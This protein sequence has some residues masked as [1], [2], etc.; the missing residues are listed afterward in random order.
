MKNTGFELQQKEMWPKHFFHFKYNNAT[1]RAKIMARRK[2]NSTLVCLPIL[3][4]LVGQATTIGQQPESILHWKNG[5]RLPGQV[6]SGNGSQTNWKSL[7]FDAPLEISNAA[8]TAIE[9]PVSDEAEK[10]DIK[11]HA[12]RLSNGDQING[13]ITSVDEKSVAIST[14]HYG[15]L[16]LDKDSVDSIS[17]LTSARR[18]RIN[19]EDLSNWKSSSGMLKRW[20]LN[21]TRRLTTSTTNATI[22]NE[23][24]L[25]D[26]V[27][28][29][30]LLTSKSQLNFVLAF[31]AT[32]NANL[33]EGLPRIESWDGTIVF[34][35]GAGNL[36]SFFESADGPLKRLRLSFVWDQKKRRIR[37]M[38]EFGRQLCDSECEPGPRDISSGVLI[39]NRST[40]L[41]VETLNVGEATIANK[42]LQTGI[43]R[44]NGEITQGKLKSFDGKQWI[45]EHDQDSVSIPA[46]DFLAACL[47]ILGKDEPT[48]NVH[49]SASNLT[50]VFYRDGSFIKGEIVGLSNDF[51]ELKTVHAD[52]PIRCLFAGLSTLQFPK[53]AFKEVI[54]SHRLKLTNTSLRGKL[55]SGTNDN[56]DVIRW[57][58]VGGSKPVPIKAADALVTL[59]KHT[60]NDQVAARK[61]VD[62]LWSDKIYFRDK[63][64]IVCDIQSIDDKGINFTSFSEKSFVAHSDV[65]AVEL[66]APVSETDVSTLDKDWYFSDKNEIVAEQTAEHFKINGNGQFDFGHPRLG[67]GKEIQFDIS[68]SDESSLEI[69]LFPFVENTKELTNEAGF[70]L[71]VVKNMI[72]L[73]KGVPSNFE[74]R[75]A[76]VKVR[77]I[78]GRIEL[79]LN[80]RKIQTLPRQASGQG[81]GIRLRSL[82]KKSAI[83][84][85]G[86]STSHTVSP[87]AS[88]NKEK[89]RQALT[90]PR[91]QKQNP[92]KQILCARNGDLLR[93]HLQSL[94]NNGIRFQSNLDDFKFTREL[95]GSIVW[96]HREEDPLAETDDSVEQVSTVENPEASAERIRPQK[97]KH[98]QFVLIDGP[99]VTM[100]L[101]SWRDG[102][103]VG[104]SEKLGLCK[105]P[106][107][108][109]IEMR[110]GRF[111]TEAQDGPYSDWVAVPAM[112]VQLEG[113][114]GA[115]SHC[116]GSALSGLVGETPKDLEL[117]MVDGSLVNLSELRGKV[118][119]LDFWATWCGPCI[120]ALPEVSRT[121]DSFDP[122]DVVLIAVNQGE[123]VEHI[124]SFQKRRKWKIQIATD[125]DSAIGKTF[126]ASSLPTT[127]V[128]DPTGKIAA[129]HVGASKNLAGQLKEEIQGLIRAKQN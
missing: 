126:E 82:S 121:V 11:G 83:T 113:G 85:S 107:T 68:W 19:F 70:G 41:T 35:D 58:P 5:D 31:G 7:F 96:L 29:D 52:V 117:K 91:L 44:F 49:K 69:D 46:T 6:I 118:V 32:E 89:K 54:A 63:D 38:D 16:I 20:S 84:F 111:A 128:I 2:F 79:L 87:T 62:M 4:A 112:E 25:P 45:V 57:M 60:R 100:E 34:T 104:T 110:I 61:A 109:I 120:Q 26:V 67:D 56:G 90:I 59:Q 88:I 101:I 66:A 86:F 77:L 125:V 123:S 116:D 80:G 71:V 27:R 55:T 93:G 47:K 108:R 127:V 39:Q 18:N 98:V 72:G 9:F 99:R 97:P 74:K 1:A 103:L 122:E 17:A 14:A 24:E 81:Y 114:G 23:S 106:F 105:I 94:N 3:F 43:E 15:D 33:I 51:V 37:I 30:V 40:D 95:V 13:N 73:K 42:N 10:A 102:V 115:H 53:V 76:R 75:K 12:V 21:A 22:Y 129:V 65:V 50:T 92:P 28:I 36:E 48:P 8:L 78:A 64:S 119:V 124:K